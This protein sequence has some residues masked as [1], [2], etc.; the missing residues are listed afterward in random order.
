MAET[1]L[2]FWSLMLFAMDC[3]TLALSIFSDL[4]A[5][6]IMSEIYENTKVFI[7][8]FQVGTS[9]GVGDLTVIQAMRE[10]LPRLSNYHLGLSILFSL[11]V[12][13]S[14]ILPSTICLLMWFLL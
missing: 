5:I 12:L 10:A 4:V 11:A 3:S 8:A 1:Y 9:L 14:Y 7:K 13:L 2:F 6:E